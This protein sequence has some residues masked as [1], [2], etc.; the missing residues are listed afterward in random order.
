[1]NAHWANLL[2]ELLPA[3]LEEFTKEE[4]GRFEISEIEGHI[5]YCHNNLSYALF[6]RHPLIDEKT[7]I[8][9]IDAQNKIHSITGKQAVSFS[10]YD[11]IRNPLRAWQKIQGSLPE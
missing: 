1:M 5:T 4:D 11:F 3:R 6:A 2:E 7:C 10:I 8:D 9:V